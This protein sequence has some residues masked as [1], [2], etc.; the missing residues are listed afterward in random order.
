MMFTT[1]DLALPP[2]VHR[3]ETLPESQSFHSCQ[4][5]YVSI[6]HPI[7]CG[8]AVLLLILTF[9]LFLLAAIAIKLT[10]RGPILYSQTRLGRRGR[11]YPIFKIRTMYHDCER[12]SGICWSSKGDPRVTPVG[13]FLRATHID[14]LPQLWNI[15]RGDMSLVGPRPERPEFLP[16]LE[17]KLL[18]YRE[19]L[20]VRP[21]ITGL[22]QV[23]LPAD[24][25]IES[26]RRKLAQDLLYI[27]TLSFWL[28][29]RIM[30]STVLHVLGLK[31]VVG[32]FLLTPPAL[33][34]MHPGQKGRSKK[35]LYRHRCWASVPQP[36]A[37]PRRC[38]WN[39]V[40]E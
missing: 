14:E 17:E 19:R 16:G 25:D 10:S 3:Q 37:P 6:K 12:K 34:D 31:F 35:F 32:R 26:V 21:G 40:L 24:T 4:G 7:E 2:A 13:R 11:P 15:L 30:I 33:A 8:L 9:P 27:Q 5:W 29:V 20:S 36:P 23:Q 38:H 39:P 18:R 22:A 1:G 28:D